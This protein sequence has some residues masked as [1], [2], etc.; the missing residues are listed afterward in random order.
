M[1][2]LTIETSCDETAAAVTEGT[3]ILSSVKWTQEVHAKWGGVVPSL[4]K[5]AHEERIEE[6]IHRAMLNVQCSMF[7]IDAI[8]VTVGPGLAI[9]LEVG[10]KW[11]KKLAAEWHKPLIGVNHIEGHILSA[12]TPEVVFP[13][14]ALVISGGHTQII[15]VDEIGK[16]KI[17]AQS[18]DDDIGEALDKGARML[19]LPYPG[20]PALEKLAAAGDAKKY[21]LPLPMA[22]K[23][24][25]A[26][27]YS[28]LKTAF[29]RLISK[30]QDSRLNADLAACYQAMV[31]KHLTRT[32]RLVLT[33]TSPSNPSP[34]LGEGSQAVQDLLVG[35]G[36]AANQNLKKQLEE[37]GRELGINVRYPANL[38]LCTDN[39]AMIGVAA[40]FKAAR[41]E[42]DD[43]DKIDRLPRWRVDEII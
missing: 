37:L 6:I 3:E 2:I 39:A 24:G 33:N 22:G 7:N 26:F 43:L 20:G 36:V 4:A 29:Y 28:G 25:K 21:K 9:A 1:K 14:M 34:N 16:Y 40:G 8:A 11:A 38:M 15:R 13:C 30:T 31:F 5:R 42:F 23:E 17:L 10:I 35:G 32:V 41:G 18:L 19:G 27:S 12:L